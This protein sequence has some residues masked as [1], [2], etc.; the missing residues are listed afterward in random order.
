MP[1]ALALGPV[2]RPELP[3]E[4]QCI[5]APSVVARD[6]KLVMFYAGAYNNEPQQIG[7]AASADGVTW[8]RLSESP[9][10]P[11]GNPREWNSSESGH[12]GAF[13]DRDGS[14][15]LFFQGNNDNGKTWYLSSRKVEWR[16][17]QPVVSGGF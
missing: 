1:G 3:W 7:A 16:G 8:K 17:G 4:R 10:L 12:P 2:L 15:R 14:T 13:V 6:G 11:V 9:V 5:E